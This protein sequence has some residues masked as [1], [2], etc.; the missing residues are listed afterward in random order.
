MVYNM[1][2]GCSVMPPRNKVLSLCSYHAHPV[3]EEGGEDALGTALNTWVSSSLEQQFGAYSPPFF[4]PTCVGRWGLEPVV[5][6]KV[7]K[8]SK[9]TLIFFIVKGMS[10]FLPSPYCYYCFPCCARV[11]EASKP[12]LSSPARLLAG[13]VQLGQ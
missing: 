11:G 12:L 8:A 3:P 4:S 6:F 2:A 7:P 1:K 13:W 10:P 5:T 9:N